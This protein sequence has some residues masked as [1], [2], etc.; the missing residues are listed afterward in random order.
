MVCVHVWKG[1]LNMA[2][3]KIWAAVMCVA[4]CFLS[5]PLVWIY[6]EF[7]KDI[8]C[9]ALL[10]HLSVYKA[11]NRRSRAVWGLTLYSLVVPE[12]PVCLRLLWV[13]GCDLLFLIIM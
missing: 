5:V 2:Q 12:A 8:E 7:Y 10:S 9:G 13:L 4:V 11:W 3:K 1:A 6:S